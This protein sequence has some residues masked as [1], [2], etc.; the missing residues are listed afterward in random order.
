MTKCNTLSSIKKSR[1]TCMDL[2]CGFGFGQDDIFVVSLGKVRFDK[3][4]IAH[5]ATKVEIFSEGLLKLILTAHL[6]NRKPV[7]T[8]LGG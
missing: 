5:N 2:R 8:V 1:I 6:G 3:V 4:I 7:C